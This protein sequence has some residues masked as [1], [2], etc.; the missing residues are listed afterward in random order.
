[1]AKGVKLNIKTQVSSGFT[2]VVGS[3]GTTYYY[4]FTGGNKGVP[5]GGNQNEG[6]NDFEF[7]DPPVAETF[8]VVFQ[9]VP[10]NTYEFPA[11]AFVSKTEDSDLTGSNT[12]TT[13]TVSDSGANRPVVPPGTPADF[14][15]GVKVEVTETGD[16]LAETFQCDP[17]VSNRHN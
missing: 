7:G 3:K 11:N 16:T 2:S 17:M 6:N 13:V 5:G 4:K 1:M 9:G 8:T 15:Y 14:S 12:S 10:P